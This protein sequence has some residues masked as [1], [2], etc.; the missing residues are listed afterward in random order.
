MA[1]VS[2]TVEND[3]F[4][5]PYHYRSMQEMILIA[6]TWRRERHKYSKLLRRNA[7]RCWPYPVSSILMIDQMICSKNE[8]LTRLYT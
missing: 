4:C 1:A 8:E 2:N 7:T 5:V 6:C 3:G